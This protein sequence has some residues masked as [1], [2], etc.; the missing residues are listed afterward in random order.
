MREEKSA[1]CLRVW[2]AGHSSSEMH[3]HFSLPECDSDDG[4]GVKGT[5]VEELRSTEGKSLSLPHGSVRC[6]GGLSFPVP[7]LSPHSST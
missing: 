2:K 6:C 4:T 7:S 3:L 5:P 1:D